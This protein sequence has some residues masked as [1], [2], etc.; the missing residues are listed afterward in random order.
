MSTIRHPGKILHGL[1]FVPD[2]AD[3]VCNLLRDVKRHSEYCVTE[4][5]GHA[6]QTKWRL[7]RMDVVCGLG[8]DIQERE[9]RVLSQ[10]A[11]NIVLW[12]NA[13]RD[14]K[15]AFSK[16]GVPFQPFQ[17]L[18]VM[19]FL[20][21]LISTTCPT[22]MDNIIHRCKRALSLQDVTTDEIRAMKDRFSIKHSVYIIPR[23]HGKTSMFAALMAATVLFIDNIRI[24]YGC[25]RRKPLEEA[26]SATN[27]VIRNIRGRFGE[28]DAL[29]VTTRRG[30]II[31]VHRKETKSWS[32]ILFIPLQNDKVTFSGL[33]CYLCLF[34][35]LLLYIHR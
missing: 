20:F 2:E 23:R 16:D 1:G 11:S 8:E 18:M 24:G 13:V 26:F 7:A 34:T 21:Y 6:R 35:K 31:N 15:T 30:E 4:A 25:H 10:S 33:I 29:K 14:T 17:N 28:L 9:D 5:S 19:D 3:V 32:N 12:I 22:E 27:N